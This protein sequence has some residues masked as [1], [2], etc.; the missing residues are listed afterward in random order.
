[1]STVYEIS[2]GPLTKTTYTLTA[3]RLRVETQGGIGG[4]SADIPISA[5]TGFYARSRKVRVVG[6]RSAAVRVS[7]EATH[8]GGELLVAWVEGGARKTKRFLVDTENAAFR[9]L[10]GELASLRPDASL[11]RL[12][13][14]AAYDRLGLWTPDKR[15]KVIIV[16]VIAAL[17]IGGGLVA[18]LSPNAVVRPPAPTTQQRR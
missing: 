18:A 9:S 4:A 11:L 3:E 7:Q 6:P 10:L 12:S 5:I 17:L 8:S 13:V 16:A 14:E 2:Y 15:A 1:M